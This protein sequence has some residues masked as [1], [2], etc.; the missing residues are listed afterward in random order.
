MIKGSLGKKEIY[1]QELIQ[2]A[3]RSPAYQL[4]PCGFLSLLSCS[5]QDHRHRDWHHS[6]LGPS[7]SIINQRKYLTGLPTG[8]WEHLLSQGFLF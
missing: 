7:T 2:R 8:Y 5:F 4:V 3:G 6:E 1:G